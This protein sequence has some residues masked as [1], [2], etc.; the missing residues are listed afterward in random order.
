MEEDEFVNMHQS[1]KECLKNASVT[2]KGKIRANIRSHSFKRLAVQEL[3]EYLP[4]HAFVGRCG[5]VVKNIHTLYDYMFNSKRQDANAGK[6]LQGWIF[7]VGGE[8]LGGLPPDINNIRTSPA[9]VSLFVN[10]L[11][12]ESVYLVF[13]VIYLYCFESIIFVTNIFRERNICY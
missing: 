2:T 5:W 7:S 6:T 10:A 1:F 3:Q 13:Q 11:F 12:R 9:K 8:V 4:P